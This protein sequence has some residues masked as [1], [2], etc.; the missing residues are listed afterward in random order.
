MVGA[1]FETDDAYKLTHTNTT[2]SAIKTIADTFYNT[3][4]NSYSSLFATNA[5]FCNDRSIATSAMTWASDDTATGYGPYTTYYRAY[6][7]IVNLHQPQF[8]CPNETNDLFTL[9]TSS[10]GNKKLTKPIGLLTIDEV[11][12]AGGK[13]FTDNSNYYLVKNDHSWVTMSPYI[14]DYGYPYMWSV[15]ESGV[16]KVGYVTYYRGIRPA[17]NLSSSVEIL[18]NGADGTITKPY[19][20]KVS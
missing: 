2:D 1:T 12:Y 7:R 20:I 6:N 19:T 17:I 3:H 5:G 8:K 16:T 13:S 10:K 14:Y 9:T 4:L 18:D 11:M 15:D